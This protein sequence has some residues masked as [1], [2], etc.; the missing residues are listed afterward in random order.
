MGAEVKMVRR[1]V[2]AALG[3]A[4]AL[5]VAGC[6]GGGST[7]SKTTGLTKSIYTAGTPG[8]TPVHGGTVTIARP[9][10]PESMDPLTVGPPGE[11]DLEVA[12]FDQLTESFAPS[13]EP[14]PALAQSWST[15][16]DGKTI[17]F[18]IRSGVQFS[19]GEPLTAEDVLYSLNRL[20]LPN[21]SDHF[22]S[23]L[24][25]KVSSPA[26]LTVV[27]QLKKP[28]PAFVDDVSYVGA[29]IVPK[30][31][32]EH[33]GQKAFAVHPVGSGPFEISSANPGNT[34]VTMVRNPHYWRPGLPYLEKLVWNQVT[35]ANSRVLAVRSGAATIA[36][37]AA[38]SQVATL[39]STPGVRLLVEPL[40]GSAEEIFNDAAHPFNEVNVRRAIAYATPVS[41]IIKSVYGGLGLPSNDVFGNMV[42]YWDPHAP[43]FPYDI[44][45]AKEL[46]KGTSVPNGFN[47]TILI[48]AGEPELA[49]TAAIEQN[50]W[51]QIG[52]HAKIETL[53]PSSAFSNYFAGKYQFFIEPPEGSVIET[54]FPD[55][56]SLQAEDY[57]D[58][59]TKSSGSN[60]NSPKATELIRK[61]VTTQSESE[62]EKLFGE[63]QE[64]V[65][66]KEAG[67]LS[68]A[69]LPKLTLVS[70][71]LRG[72]E[73]P[74]T[75]Y[76]RMERAWLEN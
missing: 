3:V 31:L 54:H 42:K 43:Y 22:L 61:A 27:V 71:K 46:L 32:I 45:K 68:I 21:A 13:E 36:T 29:S 17:T 11:S 28:T 12:I 72:F 55:S 7:S 41:S 74:P 39:R 38:F 1:N 58:S 49:L 52:V 66:F 60:Y 15:S 33:E 57:P 6:G 62:R 65:N 34:T 10:A 23:T 69:F 56:P 20:T 53:Q 8:G 40:S 2:I 18:H 16:T 50:A 67:Y 30:R 51:S 75:G 14:Q 70:D 76:Y 64:L 9:E 26:P 19:N 35:E 4:T 25:E 59:G 37:D 5:A 47:M 48:P 44:A 24:W 73:V 63:I